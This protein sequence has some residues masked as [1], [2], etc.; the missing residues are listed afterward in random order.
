[1]TKKELAPVT[2]GEMLKGTTL[3][4]RSPP[5]SDIGPMRPRRRYCPRSIF[6]C[7]IADEIA[8]DFDLIGIVIR[9]FKTG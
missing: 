8:D 1:M 2:P 7:D 3:L 9:D 6:V 4:C 5:A